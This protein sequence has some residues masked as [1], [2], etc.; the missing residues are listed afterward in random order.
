MNLD[1]ETLHQLGGVTGFG[2]TASLLGYLGTV[3]GIGSGYLTRL[4]TDPHSFLYAGAILFLA[5]FGIDR[6]VTRDDE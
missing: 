3:L 6:L 2:W 5:T 1:S 4:A